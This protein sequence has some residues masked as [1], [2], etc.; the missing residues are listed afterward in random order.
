MIKTSISAVTE[1]AYNVKFVLKSQI[2]TN[3]TPKK[4]I[5][6]PGDIYSS[7]NPRYTFDTF[8]IGE[9]NSM[10]QAAA[11]AVAEAPGNCLALLHQGQETQWR[12]CSARGQRPAF[13]PAQWY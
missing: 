12:G 6:Q 2:G 4:I 7:L 10:A 9:N 8:V 11:L 3:D 13:A 5:K 1:H